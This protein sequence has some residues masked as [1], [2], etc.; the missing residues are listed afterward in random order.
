MPQSG[1]DY[2]ALAKQFGGTTAPPSPSRARAAVDMATAHGI[3]PQVDLSGEPAAPDFAAL[4]RQFGGTA[5]MGHTGDRGV[6]APPGPDAPRSPADA[7]SAARVAPIASV[8]GAPRRTQDIELRDPSAPHPDFRVNVIGDLPKPE[9]PLAR[10]DDVA[11]NAPRALAAGAIRFNMGIWGPLQAAADAL[12]LKDTANWFAAAG[13]QA[14]EMATA[15]RGPQTGAGPTEQAVYSGFESIGLNVPAIAAGL[16]SGNPEVPL[17]MMGA[18]TGGDAYR[19][20]RAKGADGLHAFTHA[21]SQGA[22][23]VATERLPVSYLL[24]DLAG[25]SGVV[26][27]LLRQMASE[28]P[29]EQVATLFQDLNDWATLHPEQPFSSYLKD[30]PGAAAQTLVATVVGT[31]GQSAG[32]LAV[33][34]ALATATGRDKPSQVAPDESATAATAFASEPSEPTASTAPTAS[35]EAVLPPD[36]VPVGEEPVGAP[37]PAPLTPEDT[38]DRV[39]QKIATGQPLGTPGARAALAE[40]Q[41]RDQARESVMPET[42]VEGRAIEAAPAAPTAGEFYTMDPAAITVDPARF[43]FKRGGNAQGVT[44]AAKIEGPWNE[45]RAGA[46]MVWRDPK[47]GQTYVVNGHHRLEAATR[48]GAPRVAVRFLEAPTAKA[49]RIEGALTNITEDKGTPLDAAKLI[50]DAGFTVDDL[51]AQGLSPRAALVRDGLGL[52]QLSDPLFQKVVSGEIDEKTGGAIG[53]AGLSPEGQAAVAKLVERQQAKGRTLTPAQ[54]RALA[55]DVAATPEVTPDNGGQADIFGLMGEE[56]TQNVAVEKAILRDWARQEL[57]KDKR[58]F[59]FVAKPGRADALAKGGNVINVGQSKAIADEAGQVAAVFDQLAQAMGPVSGALNA[60]A[61]KMAAGEASNEVKR[62]LLNDL[63]AA[64][65][66]ELG[67]PAQAQ[68]VDAGREATGVGVPEA[69]HSERRPANS[70]A[71]VDEAEPEHEFASTQVNLPEEAAG[72]IRALAKAIPDG[73]LAEDGRED[74]PHITVKFGLHGNDPAVVR[75]LLA[76]EGPI[77]V[78]FGKISIFPNGESGSGDVV[79]IDIDSPGLHRLN[80]KIADALPNTDTHP[81]Y[82]PHATIAYVK[83]GLGQKYAE[84]AN[85]LEGRSVTLDRLIFSDKSRNHIEIPLIG[86]TRA[87]RASYKPGNPFADRAMRAREKSDRLSGRRNARDEAMRASFPLGAGFGRPGDRSGKGIE[88]TVN[89]AVET[90]QAQK[91]ADYLEAQARAFDE[92]KINAQGRAWGPQQEARAEKRATRQAT[93]DERIAT[94]REAKGDK[95]AW[96][97]PAEVWADASGNLGGGARKLVLAGHRE[98][99]ET[100][101]KEGQSVPANVLAGYPDLAV[102]EP[103]D[104]L[105]DPPAELPR[106]EPEVAQ[107]PGDESTAPPAAETGPDAKR[108][109][110]IERIVA[111]AR[112]PAPDVVERFH[113]KGTDGKWYNP[114]ANSLPVGVKFTGERES[115]GWVTRTNDGATVGTL[116]KFPTK[117]AIL[118]DFKA[119]QDADDSLLREDLQKRDAQGLRDAADYWLHGEKG[120]P[121]RPPLQRHDALMARLR[122]G[123]VDPEDLREGFDRTVTQKA[124]LLTDLGQMTKA[125]LLKRLGVLGAA[126]YKSDLKARVVEAAYQD[127]LSDFILGGGVRFDGS[128]G[129]YESS[130]RALVKGYTDQDIADFAA[131]VAKA[132]ED[133]KARVEGVAKALK[134]PETLEEFDQFVRLDKRGEAGLTPEQVTRYDE[135]RAAAGREKRQTA[136]QARGTVQPASERVDATIVETTHTQKG[137]PLFVVQLAQRVSR[138]DYGRLLGAAKRLG[139]WYSSFKGRGAVPGFQFKTREGADAFQRLASGGDTEAVTEAITERRDERKDDRREA[140]VAKLKEMADR[141]E[142]KA[143][144]ALSTNRL[145]NTARRARMADSAEAGARSEVA[146]AKT[147]RRVAEAIEAGEVTHLDGLRTKAQVDLLSAI[148]KRAQYASLKQEFPQYRDYERNKDRPITAEDAAHA[149]FPKVTASKS[150]LLST[151]GRYAEEKGGKRLAGQMEALARGL[152]E[153]ERVPVPWLIVEGAVEHTAPGTFGRNS[154][155]TG[156]RGM[157]SYYWEQALA[158]KRRLEAMGIED[159]PALRAALREFIPLRS[160]APKADK[161]KQLERALAGRPDVGKDFFPTPEP[162]AQQMAEALDV[163]PGMR[164]LEPSAGKG[165]LADAVRAAQPDAVIDTVEQSSTLREILRAKGYDLV[166]QTFEDFTPEAPYD[167]VIMN[168][169]FS[170]GLDADHVRK[171]YDLLKPGGKLIAITGEGIFF[172]S[173]AKSKAFRDWLDGVGGTS[174]KMA[175]AFMDRREVK[176]TGVASRLVTIEKPGASDAAAEPYSKDALQAAFNLTP[177]QAEAADV[178]VQAM[179]LDT[180]QIRVAKGGQPGDGALRQG[181]PPEDLLD[182]GERQPRLP[183]AGA[184]R[185]REVPTPRLAEPEF[186]L[187]AE[188]AKAKKAAQP[189]LFQGE[190]G[191]AEFAADGSAIIRGFAAADVSTGL[192]EIAHVARRQLL[193]REVPVEQ[194]RGLTDADIATTETWAGAT[195]GEWTVEAEEKFARGFERYLRDGELP[196]TPKGVRAV[197]AQVQAWLSDI[198]QSLVGSPLDIDVSPAMR[199]VFD[200]LV[201][202]QERLETPVAS[203]AEGSDTDSGTSALPRFPHAP[204]P[205]NRGPVQPVTARTRPRAIIEN[206]R[207]ALGG[208][209]VR[210]G[211]FRA[212]AAGIFKTGPRAIRLAVA[213]DLFTYFHEQGHDVD[214]TLLQI[215]RAD[216]RWKD[217]LEA[218]GEATSRPSYTKAQVRKEGAA[219]FLRTWVMDPLTLSEVAPAYLTAFEAALDAHPKVKNALTNARADY[220]ALT[221][222]DPATQGA[223]TINRDAPPSLAARVANDPND[224]LE[225]VMTA[226]ADDLQPIKHAVEAMR[227]GRPLAFMHNAW[228]LAREARG[229]TAKAEAFLRLGVRGMNGQFIGPSF[230]AVLAPLAHV[231]PATHRANL[232]AF[233]DYLVALRSVELLGRDINPGMTRVQAQALITRTEAR[234]DFADFAT[235]RESFYRYHEALLDYAGQYGAFS[236]QQLAQIKALNQAYAPMQRVMDDVMTAFQAGVSKRLV[237]RASPIKRIKGSGREVIDPLESTIGNTF[238]IVD[239]VEKNRAAVALVEQAETAAGSARWIERIPTPQVA[240]RFNL[241]TVTRAIGTALE[242]A[243]LDVPTNLDDA[244]DQLVTVFTPQN[245]AT[246]KDDIVTVIRDGHR[247]FW[248][249]NQPALYDALNAIGPRDTSVLLQWLEK[250]TKLL[251]ATATLTPGFITRNPFRDTLVAFLQSRYGFIPGY[252]TARGL[253]SQIKGDEAARLFYTS[254]VAQAGLVAQDRRHRQEALRQISLNPT[255]R[256]RYVALHPVE[257]LRALSGWL[258]VATRLG[259]FKLALEAGGQERGIVERLFESEPAPALTEEVLV[260]ATL[261]ARDV[262]TDFGQGGRLTKE[263]N[264]YFAFLNARVRG[265]VR[266]AEAVQ[267]DPVGVGVKVGLLMLASAALYWLN[268]DDDAYQELPEWEKHTYWHFRVGAIFVRVPKPFEWGYAADLSEAMMDELVQGADAQRL[269]AIEQQL[270][271]GNA[272]KVVTHLL[273]TAILP[274]V[275]A[276]ANYSAFRDTHIVRPWDTD[277]PS[278][279][280]YSEWTS[281]VAK[282]LGRTSAFTSLGLSPAILDHLIAGYTAGFGV[283]VVRGI[284]AAGAVTGALPPRK[285]QPT[286]PWE[287]T[288]ALGNFVRNATVGASSESIQ[289]L[290]DLAEAITTVEKGIAAD[291]ASRRR[292]AAVRRRDAARTALPWDQKDRI[293]RA[294]KALTDEGKTI[295]AIYAASPARMTPDEKRARL[296]RVYERMVAIARRGLGRAR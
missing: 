252:D 179:G 209:P 132:R 186:R 43:Q 208:V 143:E 17:A 13:K 116:N 25:H 16:A 53:G 188:A 59:G 294:R 127:L 206:L 145:A 22:I 5:T 253:I 144:G 222:Q 4:A 178:L 108:T 255:E 173:D 73:D 35:T 286:A 46:L 230:R 72:E 235:A 267:R 148:A 157:L 47:D 296:D 189:T 185:D 213:N 266:M 191:A 268:K 254:G 200:R 247:E 74:T 205:S 21:V 204:L 262:T 101:L 26:K 154:T 210:T 87:A 86:D 281:E 3:T 195:D 272:K 29:G 137:Y 85:P 48:L 91:D 11:V 75:K 24:K 141:L 36:L 192:H 251:R 100:A 68:P 98:A 50:R 18:T 187:T 156:A 155:R 134:N 276:W 171:A 38:V 71:L 109:A 30:R 273:P 170:D 96:Q 140:A 28:I 111:A 106:E 158:E 162:V 207:R 19:Q 168:P 51:V 219:E 57:A 238:A 291:L 115:Q 263:A 118:A 122:E 138:E 215:D 166:G 42:A 165:N 199:A 249:V 174:E 123:D 169:P 110:L 182:T 260:R 176:T 250:P 177:E 197:F 23:E 227:D 56:R 105:V 269:H 84:A 95:L 284:D 49:A 214:L 131:R 121:N 133:R 117:D 288:P 289:D 228:V 274:A 60:A 293:L 153:N 12:G 8:L 259:E 265:Y 216:P 32:A 89:H 44:S 241:K 261:A 163:Q 94:A 107:R 7:V 10:L 172:R 90:V 103:V 198:Y 211:R 257:V 112:R 159:L 223:L 81:E 160:D 83:P 99:V 146:L 283:G 147:M 67:R 135:L 39:R 231:T 239:M 61:G 92:G 37:T 244:L 1:V 128:A 229:A 88:Q 183:E 275:E 234:T 203:R 258:E 58:L 124:A 221:S 76:D 31:L 93:R 224:Y 82:Q 196:T 66:A 14:D 151:A 248:Q 225:R 245:F 104:V 278:D 292:P 55:E 236:P 27:T 271:G 45:A 79:K 287:R 125:D 80:Q 136:E 161:V 220:D 246:G 237:N 54:V 295:R 119:R 77:T 190:K 184:V 130:I 270:F 149:T 212:L 181:E 240:T 280:Q 279:L 65:Q 78:T 97:V 114:L 193:N 264:R 242:D 113:E 218:L 226:V 243:G 126:R 33:D 20:A 233:G 139:G 64:V 2:A 34:H 52:A 282:A 40:Q 285:V 41:T 9:G 202:R 62:T 63:R 232:V 175:D 164:V 201:S 277:L 120:G 180:D 290:Y 150:D 6:P 102:E 69:A 142:T 217:E 152:D 167:R 15:T 70:E 256:L 194:R 129:G